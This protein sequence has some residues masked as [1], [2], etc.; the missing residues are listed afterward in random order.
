LE[1]SSATL[2]YNTNEQEANFEYGESGDKPVIDNDVNFRTGLAQGGVETYTPRALI[3]DLKGSII[4][5][6]LMKGGFGSMR[7]YNELYEQYSDVD[8]EW[9]ETSPGRSLCLGKEPFRNI[10]NRKLKYILIKRPS[11]R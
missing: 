10:T 2:S 3:Y 5:E 7:K 11:A 4:L 9:Y 6:L 1:C 8:P